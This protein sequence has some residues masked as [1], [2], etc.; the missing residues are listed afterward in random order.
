[1][2]ALRERVK[3]LRASLAHPLPPPENLFRL[4][5]TI[6]TVCYEG[7][8]VHLKDGK[9]MRYLA[10]LLRHP[11]IERHVLELH[12]AV[13]GTAPM[14]AG[15]PDQRQL[16]DEHL[17]IRMLGD[18][19]AVLDERAKL[20]YRRRLADL[21]HDLEDA[22]ACWDTGR[23]SR[24]RAEIE[25]L[26]HALAAAYGLGGRDTRAAS[27]AERA[28]ISAT[29]AIRQTIDRIAEAHPLLGEHLRRSVRT[30]RFF[31]Y[32]SDPPVEWVC[33]GPT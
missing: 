7:R 5:G 26:E 10:Q 31:C 16:A 32:A 25:A 13:A 20:E 6:W 17:G 3:S 2:N 24:A 33:E 28:R 22:E 29:K 23:A 1:M 15:P 27:A 9:G 4:D 14:D 12:S 21:R 8:T 30:G 19:G 11:A 18:A